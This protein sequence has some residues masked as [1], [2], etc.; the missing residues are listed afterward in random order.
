MATRVGDFKRELD[1][2]T[3]ASGEAR[4]N[5]QNIVQ[6]RGMTELFECDFFNLLLNTSYWDQANG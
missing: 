3:E 2:I 4:Y 1:K 6:N 5:P